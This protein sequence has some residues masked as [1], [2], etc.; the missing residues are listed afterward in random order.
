MRAAIHDR[1][2]SPRDVVRV[3]EVAMPVP[4]DDRVL[5]RVEAASVNRVDLDWILPHPGFVRLLTGVRRPRVQ[6][7]GV[8]VAGVVEAV[9]PEAG[10]FAPGDRVFADLYNHGHGSF[11]EYVC[12]RERAF[13]RIPEHMTSEVAA[14][15]PHAAIL[16]I[17]GLRRSDG[18]TPGQG[19]RVLIEGAGGN[20]GPFAVQIAKSYGAVV[21]AVD[22]TDKLDLLRS[23]GADV[24]I[25]YT[26]TDYTRLD[27]RYDWI[28]AVD[29]HHRMT[30]VR[31]VL[32]R[33]G[34]YQF[35]G[36][37]ASS[38]VD[39]L[40]VGT[41]ATL[42]SGKTMGLMLGWRPFRAEDVDTL[43]RMI[44][45]GTLRP[46]IDRRYLLDEVVQALTLVHEGRARGKV[47]V[48]PA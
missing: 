4:D 16:A 8:D 22:H 3:D 15:L 47:I 46:A 21:T 40:F 34:I 1:Y 12:A 20:V 39:G 32:R 13:L 23:L 2:G 18:R 25:D 33:G 42:A 26:T 45:E 44:L 9:G 27:E 31:R 29:A 35:L 5:V 10:M 14:T 19:D 38:L 24:V 43:C 48:T 41:A 28:L 30:A 37:P 17:Q 7:V 11:A 6:R 36:G